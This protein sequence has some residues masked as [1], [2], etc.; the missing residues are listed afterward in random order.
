MNCAELNE[1]LVDL[2]DG[3]LDGA[4]QRSVERHLEG[5]ATCRALVEEMRSIRGAA[6]ML[7]RHEPKA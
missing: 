3:R 4:E 1:A 2:V 5:C 7:D 6:F